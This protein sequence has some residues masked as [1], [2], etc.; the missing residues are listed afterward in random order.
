MVGTARRADITVVLAESAVP[1]AE[2]VM[3]ADVLTWQ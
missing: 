2:L 3:C 1:G